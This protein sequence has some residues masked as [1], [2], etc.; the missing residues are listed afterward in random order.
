ML[1]REAVRSYSCDRA[2]ST[3][4]H[5]TLFG[6]GFA[7]I[8]LIASAQAQ[9]HNQPSSAKAGRAVINQQAVNTAQQQ[10]AMMSNSGVGMQGSPGGVAA[11]LA[12]GDMIMT[13][14]MRRSFDPRHKV[15]LGYM[16]GEAIA[17]WGRAIH[18][19]DKT[20]TESE[21]DAD[22]K[23]LEQR[24]KS[25]NGVLLQRR[26]ILLDQWG[27]P[28]EILIYDG[29]GDFKYRGIQIY[30]VRGRFSEEQIYD[31]NDKLIRRK[32]QE[33]S[34]DGQKMPVR[35]WD[36]IE[37]VP[38][39]LKLVI[40]RESE[41]PTRQVA[42]NNREEKQKKNWFGGNSRPPQGN[43]PPQPVAQPMQQYQAAPPASA[44]PAKK[45]GLFGGKGLFRRT[46]K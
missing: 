6:A 7:S 27:R 28:A 12:G 21:L 1:A 42:Q 17:V 35:S 3:Q 45:K 10:A 36:Y 40:T 4:T 20:Y 46:K 24:T 5:R 37:N 19:S 32:V 25:E 2:M 39:D 38:D 34:P 41:D 13:E 29:R 22:T 44:E 31:P 43:T 14:D 16:K 11:G 15:G 23:S 30:D 33:Y 9:F 8:F 18:H 26:Q